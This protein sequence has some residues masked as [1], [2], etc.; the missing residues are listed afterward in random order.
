MFRVHEMFTMWQALATFK[1]ARSHGA[2]LPCSR[3]SS[4][5]TCLASS[6]GLFRSSAQHHSLH[7][8]SLSRNA[9]REARRCRPGRSPVNT[10]C[11]STLPAKVEEQRAQVLTVLHKTTSLLP[12]ILSHEES[13]AGGP[14]SRESLL[15]WEDV[16]GK[17]YEDLTLTSEKREKDVVRVVGVC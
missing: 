11:A 7:I 17:V 13:S 2:S 15:F 9:T 10:R 5:P 1:Q 4:M 12:R 14:P 6:S 8:S 3:L 16:L